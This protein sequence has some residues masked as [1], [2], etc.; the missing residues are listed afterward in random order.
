MMK[1][2]AIYWGE[3]MQHEPHHGMMSARELRDIVTAMLD[4]YYPLSYWTIT[5]SLENDRIVL[6]IYRRQGNVLL[7]TLKAAIVYRPGD[8]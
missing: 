4:V 6:R 2:F 1:Y 7:I 8:N 5:E 3:I